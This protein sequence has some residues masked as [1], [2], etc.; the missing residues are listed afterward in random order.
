MTG[1]SSSGSAAAV[2]AGFVPIALGS[3]AGG[4]VRIPAALCG[5]MGLKATFGRV[6]AVGGSPLCYTLDHIGPM[7]SSVW[8]LAATLQIIAGPDPRDRASRAQPGLAPFDP[9]TVTSLRGRRVGWCPKWLE[10]ADGGV[11]AVFHEALDGLRLGGA[12]ISEVTIP[13]LE[14]VQPVGIVTLGAEAATSQQRWLKANRSKYQ[15]DTRMLLALGESIT[16]VEYLHAQRVRQLICESFEAALVSCDVLVSPTAG[17]VAPPIPPGALGS[18]MVDH[19]LNKML[20]H[21][22][23]AGNLTGFPCLTLP[24]PV[25]RGEMPVGLQLMSKPWSERHLLDI[26]AAVARVFPD[27]FASP[28]YVDI[29]NG[30]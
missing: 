12:E 30:S 2:A 23:F 11:Q 14:Q 5:V 4:S 29:G 24:V 3:D 27:P 19:A 22:S 8:G 28:G 16:A 20:S 15:P 7:A 25:E 10:G 26:A 9:R 17:C 13:H 18:G 1:G 6:P 21:F